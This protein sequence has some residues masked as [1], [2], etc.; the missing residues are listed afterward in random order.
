MVS[1]LSLKFLSFVTVVFS[2]ISVVE[3]E[4]P[5]VE[6]FLP[7]ALNIKASHTP[8]K[9]GTTTVSVTWRESTRPENNKNKYCDGGRRWRVGYMEFKSVDST[10]EN[11]ETV[12]SPEFKWFKTPK[13]STNYTIP[14]YKFSNTSYYI[15]MV[16]HRPERLST[17]IYPQNYSSHVYYFGKQ[18]KIQNSFL[19]FYCSTYLILQWEW[20]LTLLWTHPTPSLWEKH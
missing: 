4:T 12:K 11:F 13:R 7:K 1:E 14:D 8:L 18:S 15:F 3:L 6:C 10:P 2:F 9:N 19:A 16:G 20:L 17:K 5:T